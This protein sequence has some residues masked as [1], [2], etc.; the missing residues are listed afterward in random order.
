MPLDAG[1]M[2]GRLFVS[3]IPSDFGP[4][5]AVVLEFMGGL[6]QAPSGCR[7]SRLDP[8]SLD[9]QPRTVA[10]AR[11]VPAKPKAVFFPI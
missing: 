1:I 10:K 11:A 4:A 8:E 6:A 2:L 7:A 3:E 9:W 5:M